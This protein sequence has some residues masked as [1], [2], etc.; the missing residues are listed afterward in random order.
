VFAF[1][2]WV[3]WC[4]YLVLHFVYQTVKSNVE[5][6]LSDTLFSVIETVRIYLTYWTTINYVHSSWLMLT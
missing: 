1:I 5:I 4:V 6:M 2:K 3:I